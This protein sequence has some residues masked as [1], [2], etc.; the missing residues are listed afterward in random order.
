MTEKKFNYGL[1]LTILFSV[2]C[3]LYMYPVFMI[4]ANSFKQETAISTNTVFQ[5]PTSN[6]FNGIGNY[7][8]AV[9]SRGFLSSL[10]YSFFITVSSVSLILFCSS[11]TAW[12]ISRIKSWVSNLIYFLCALAMVVPF[13][14]L[15]FSLSQTA[16]KLHIGILRFNNPYTIC[17]VYLG[18][19]TG[20]VIF[21]FCG[22]LKS[23]PLGIEEAALIDGCTPWQTYWYVILP[24]LKPTMISVGVLETMWIWNDYLLPTLVLNMKDYR[25][26]PMLIQFFRGSYGSVE[27]GP[28]MACIVLTIVPVILFYIIGQK[29]IIKGIVAGAVKG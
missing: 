18:F 17:L 14:T 20:M 1:L 26:I 7:V 24:M 6:T 27:M 19:G 9:K 4:I 8:T 5:L 16:D 28:M 13:Q 2:V 25:T 23:I 12:Y 22:V 21:I 10:F 3:A 15:M 11:M 29:H